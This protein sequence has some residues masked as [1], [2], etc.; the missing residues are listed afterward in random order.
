VIRRD[1]GDSAIEEISEILRESIRYGLEHREEAVQY[2][3][4]WARDMG[5]DLADRFVGMYVNDLTLDYGED[6]RRAVELF[7]QKAV[8]RG[9][10][11]RLPELKFV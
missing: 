5:Y 7:L 9:Y 1:L 3:L 8:E 4:Q 10:L 2:S 11:P 6:G